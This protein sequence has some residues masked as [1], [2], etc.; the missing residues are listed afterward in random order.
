[1]LSEN[2]QEKDVLLSKD[3]HCSLFISEK[4]MWLKAVKILLE[5]P[6]KNGYK[7]HSQGAEI[8]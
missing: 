6:G 4:P 5:G 8:I 7:N 3:W 2:I 1:M